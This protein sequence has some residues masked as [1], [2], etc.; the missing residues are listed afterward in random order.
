MV[1][2]GISKGINGI[3]MTNGISIGNGLINTDIPFMVNQS[4]I[5]N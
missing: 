1:S 3:I 2:D 5:L 4:I